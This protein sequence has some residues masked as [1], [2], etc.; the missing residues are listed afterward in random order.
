[1]TLPTLI[2]FILGG[3][4]FLLEMALPGFIV[5]FFGV[6]AWVTAV[7][8][9]LTPIGL[10]GQLALFLAGSVVSL[11]ALRG[12]VRRTFLGSSSHGEESNSIAQHGETAEVIEAI[13][14]PAEGKIRYSGTLWRATAETE[15]SKGE[16]VTILSQDG[17]VIHVV[18]GL[19]S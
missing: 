5:F 16:I 10:N 18:R 19:N 12:L 13:V 3:L 4:C 2:W 1:M 15:I 7:A 11:F 8:C 6:G 9:W 17:L 14:P